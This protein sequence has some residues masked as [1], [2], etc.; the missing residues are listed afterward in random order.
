VVDGYRWSTAL[1]MAG[2]RLKT[3]VNGRETDVLGGVPVIG[4]SAAG[5]LHI[6]WPLTNVKGTLVMDLD[7]KSIR[8][9][10]MEGAA[11]THAGRGAR[12][13]GAVSAAGADGGWFLDLTAAAGTDLPFQRIAARAMQCRFGDMG[14]SITTTKGI[15]S[16]PDDAGDDLIAWRLTP[17]DRG[18]A[19]ST[20]L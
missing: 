3:M 16:K 17:D 18:E 2:L 11:G 19:G 14:Y 6:T 9:K 20:K 13:A 8:M 4:R 15:F 1:T 12:A 10:V 7:E 5:A